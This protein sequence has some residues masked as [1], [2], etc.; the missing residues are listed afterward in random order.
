LSHARDDD[1]EE[2]GVNGLID[3]DVDTLNHWGDDYYTHEFRTAKTAKG[4][5]ADE[6]E[7]EE[8]KPG[9]IIFVNDIDKDGDNCP[10][11]IDGCL[12]H[13]HMV[14]W[15]QWE[16]HA[17]GHRSANTH[18]KFVPLKLD[19]SGLLEDV[20]E[21]EDPGDIRVWFH[22]PA[23]GSPKSGLDPFDVTA[24]GGE[25]RTQIERSV[26]LFGGEGNRFR[27]DSPGT[28]RIW[29]KPGHRN[30]SIH[31]GGDLIEPSTPERSDGYRLKDLGLGKETPVTTLWVEGI[32]PSKSAGDIRIT[33]Q[34]TTEG[35]YVRSGDITGRDSVRL[36][37]VRS[38]LGIGVVRPYVPHK[39]DVR[40]PLLLDYS[41]PY[42]LLIS[43]RNAAWQ[44]QKATGLKQNEGEAF[45]HEGGAF[46]GHGF[47][48]ITYDGPTELMDEAANARIKQMRDGCKNKKGY[49]QPMPGALRPRPPTAYFGKTG[50]GGFV[51]YGDG[52]KDVRTDLVWWRFCPYELSDGKPLVIQKTYTLH[53]GYLAR[54]FK[55]LDD[56]RNYKNFG[57][58]IRKDKKIWGWSCM[59]NVG[60]ALAAVNFPGFEKYDNGH[61]TAKWHKE[62]NLPL[63]M[64][65][66][67]MRVVDVF[68]KRLEDKPSIGSK[69][70]FLDIW[71]PVQRH[72]KVKENGKERHIKWGE[73]SPAAKDELTALIEDMWATFK[74]ECPTE[75]ESPK[76]NAQRKDGRWIIENFKHF[77]WFIRKHES[78]K[79]RFFHPELVA[80]TWKGVRGYD[81]VLP[82]E[83]G[84]K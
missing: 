51:D 23:A 83:K 37:C 40:E 62:L 27:Y 14:G 16:N 12:V 80:E 5:L 36:T 38:N 61:G 44:T 45:W 65:H 77:D 50:T 57:L 46:H 1:G 59:S 9:K 8:G 29:K 22:Y 67:V 10:D 73:T 24:A 54:I 21:E 2:E 42:A 3:L 63:T 28:I 18:E 13:H 30:R 49:R 43:V 68:L 75:L 20:G 25:H 76:N 56:D 53:P 41:S 17:V 6:I 31:P 48:W 78:R 39:N 15:L 33:V 32:W 71:K 66:G 72:Q 55:Q 26:V 35:E 84:T 81:E 7:D 11:Y 4:V 34:Y 74:D 79:L 58:H 70:A 52:R 19:V 47:A 69:N 60:I 64:Q 82:I